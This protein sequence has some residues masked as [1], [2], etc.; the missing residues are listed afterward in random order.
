MASEI[1]VQTIQHTNGTDAMTIDSSGRVLKPQ[2]PAFMISLTSGQAFT[3]AN[4]WTTISNMVDSDTNAFTQGGM[5]L[6]SGVITVPVAG[7]YHF[8]TNIRID[9]IG[10]SYFWVMISKNNSSTADYNHT[11]IDG[12]PD[13]SYITFSASGLY[14][15]SANDTVRVKVYSGADTSYTA[16]TH[17]HFSGFLVG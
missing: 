14:K 4:S 12:T 9:G 7:V 3:A 15:L 13:S 2:A 8:S 17:S 5:S 11:S 16:N 10:S 6:S 1:G